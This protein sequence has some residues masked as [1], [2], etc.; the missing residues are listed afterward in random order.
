MDVRPRRF[1]LS[2]NLGRR[3]TP[4]DQQNQTKNHDANAP[5]FAHNHNLTSW[6]RTTVGTY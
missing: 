4:T 1:P 5:L 2:S 6:H 3:D